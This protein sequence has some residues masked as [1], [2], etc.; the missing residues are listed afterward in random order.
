[1]KLNF[2]LVSLNTKLYFWKSFFDCFD[3]KNNLVL[4]KI[5]TSLE[6]FG[7]DLCKLVR[8]DVTD[9]AVKKKYK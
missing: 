2:I 7:V 8:S 6:H 9:I 1:M 4:H 5:T 3:P